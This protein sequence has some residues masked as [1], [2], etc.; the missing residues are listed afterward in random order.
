LRFPREGEVVLT[1]TVG[2]IR[3]LPADL[4]AAFKATLEEL[5]AADLLL[6]VI[7]SSDD[8]FEIKLRAVE[9]ILVDLDL[10]KIPRILVLNKCDLISDQ[11]RQSL[12][13]L[14]KGVPVSAIS[15]YGL[16]QL[17][18]AA[19]MELKQNQQ[20]TSFLA[21]SKESGRGKNHFS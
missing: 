19:E 21:E 1:D 12:A 7:D 9:K 15:G 18:S 8:R 20:A 14:Y 2:F 3:D 13:K 10:S 6:H 16:D 4:I 17:I 5:N 11:L